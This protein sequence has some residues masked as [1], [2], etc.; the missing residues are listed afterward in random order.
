MGAAMEMA[1]RGAPAVPFLEDKLSHAE[2]DKAVR[3]ITLILK[4]MQASKSYDVKS[5]RHLMEMLVTRVSQM[6]GSNCRTDCQQL[7]KR[8]REKE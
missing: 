6:K 5:D 8:I 3:D 1:E 7:I 4:F 2:D